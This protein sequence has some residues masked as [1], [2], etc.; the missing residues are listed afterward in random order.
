MTLVQK[1]NDFDPS[2]KQTVFFLSLCPCEKKNKNKAKHT[3]KS[4]KSSEK[5]KKRHGTM[6]T[7][8]QMHAN[9]VLIVN[10]MEKSVVAKKKKREIH[11]N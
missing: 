1:W 5:L 2:L 9:F 6:H 7:I 3:H 11:V 4:A 10:S 8:E